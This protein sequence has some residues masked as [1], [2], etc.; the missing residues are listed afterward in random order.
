MIGHP[1]LASLRESGDIE[2]H[3]DNVLLLHRQVAGW[4]GEPVDETTT[5]LRMAK[6]RNGPTYNYKLVWDG[7]RMTLRDA[8]DASQAQVWPTDF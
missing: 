2:A 5:E 4:S 3:A 7:E 8:P 1:S 6:C